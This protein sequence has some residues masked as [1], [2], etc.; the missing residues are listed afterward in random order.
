ME[1][2]EKNHN[3]FAEK[4]LFVSDV[5]SLIAGLELQRKRIFNLPQIK[6]SFLISPIHDVDFYVI[7]LRR[8]FRKIEDVAKEDSRVAN[9]KGKIKNF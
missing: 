8:I 3:D 7:I 5:S 1:K 4:E 9:L 6:Q 2:Q